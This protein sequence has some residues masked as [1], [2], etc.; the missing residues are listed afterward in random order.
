MLLATGQSYP[1]DLSLTPGQ[2][3][4]A[5]GL[6]SEVGNNGV[7]MV[8]KTGGAVT[9]VLESAATWVDVGTAGSAAYFVGGVSGFIPSLGGRITLSGMW[10][11]NEAGQASQFLSSSAG[12]LVGLSADATKLYWAT[13][14]SIRTVPLSGGSPV[15]LVTFSANTF[16]WFMVMDDTSLYAAS[17]GRK[18]WK[19]PKTGG[20]ATELSSGLGGS[21]SGMVNDASH[22]YVALSGAGIVKLPKTGGAAT[23]VASGDA[24]YLAADAER[25]Y[26][27]N[28]SSVVATCKNSGE[29]QVVATGMAAP[30]GIAVDNTQLYWADSDKIWKVAK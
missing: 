30:R 25:L 22:L 12:G 27:F 16:L 24:S 20:A 4:W 7:R 15:T 18:V 2:V 14:N 23:T 9:S 11:A 3:V 17:S 1:H 26:W 6:G 21:P 19:A 28:G 13:L 8:S 29:S 5:V 10:K